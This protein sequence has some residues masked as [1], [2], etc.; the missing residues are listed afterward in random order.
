MRQKANGYISIVYLPG[1]GSL[2]AR[3]LHIY[4]ALFSQ[5]AG[6]TGLLAAAGLANLLISGFISSFANESQQFA[7][8][9]VSFANFSVFVVF[10]FLYSY[11]FTASA[12]LIHEWYS[13]GRVISLKDAFKLARERFASLYWVAIILGLIFYGSSFTGILPILF[14]VWYYFAV[15]IVIFESEKGAESLA[16]SRYLLHG[17]FIKVFGRYTAII[18]AYTVF[19]LALYNLLLGLPGGWVFAFL[20]TIL[21]LYFSFPFLVAYGYLQYHDTSAV[22]RTTAFEFFRGEKAA[23]VFWAVLGFIILSVGVFFAVLTD[24]VRSRVSSTLSLQAVRI[25]MPFLANSET[26]LEK[27]TDFFGVLKQWDKSDSSAPSPD[28][29]PQY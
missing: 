29:T 9:A 21:L 20:L 15:Y 18:A 17:L 25:L 27:M 5:L 24:S 4:R 6:L 26:N 28:T 2:I 1:V 13:R 12:L 16:K 14:G 7:L 22:E 11:F 8:F 19:I 23:I 3:S 10:G